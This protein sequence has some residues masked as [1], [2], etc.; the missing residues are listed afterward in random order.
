MAEQRRFLRVA[1]EGEARL[2]FS[3]R[4]RPVELV[5]LSLRGALVESEGILPAQVGSECQLTLVLDEAGPAIPIDCR[6]THHQGR[7]VGI[8]F[9][10]MDVDAM[11]H[12][13][14]LLELNAG[15][16]DISLEHLASDEEQSDP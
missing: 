12:I 10:R 16:E 6:V 9:L 2:A 4:S 5:D 13:R 8:E 1:L 14:R 7:R 3:G 15:D 11:Q